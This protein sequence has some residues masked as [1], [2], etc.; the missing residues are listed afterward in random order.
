MIRDHPDCFG[1]AGAK[2]PW[3]TE[4]CREQKFVEHFINSHPDLS[5]QKPSPAGMDQMQR[6]TNDGYVYFSHY[7]QI[8]TTNGIRVKRA[9]GLSATALMKAVCAASRT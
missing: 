2:S 8:K 9:F 5:Q 1:V 3:Q 6:P 4:T 7:L